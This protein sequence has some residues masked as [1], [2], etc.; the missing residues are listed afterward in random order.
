MR[1]VTKLIMSRSTVHRPTPTL[2]LEPRPALPAPPGLAIFPRRLTATRSDYTFSIVFETFTERT[3]DTSSPALEFSKRV[4]YALGCLAFG[5]LTEAKAD[6]STS[7]YRD[8]TVRPSETLDL[9]GSGQF[10]GNRLRR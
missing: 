10:F 5:A 9:I 3:S 6:G 7:P 4:C 8:R 2:G 1:G